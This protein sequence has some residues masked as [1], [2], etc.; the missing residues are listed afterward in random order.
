MQTMTHAFEA[1]SSRQSGCDPGFIARQPVTGRK[2][3]QVA[4]SRER[5]WTL[6]ELSQS[7]GVPEW[8]IR[9][10]VFRG[11]LSS[12]DT[13]GT[14]NVSH[15]D[16]ILLLQRLER[17]R[18]VK[19]GIAAVAGIATLVAGSLFAGH[20]MADLPLSS[21]SAFRVS[22]LAP[23]ART[24]GQASSSNPSN[25]IIHGWRNYAKGLKQWESEDSD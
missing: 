5:C 10:Y 20:R 21:P 7:T 6:Y 18:R 13:G 14:Y 17:V 1:T 19:A 2:P 15:R 4:T 16:R 25:L 22:A 12:P 3:V 23:A 24:D 11:V 9:T 8:T